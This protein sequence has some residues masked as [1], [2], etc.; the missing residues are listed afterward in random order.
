MLRLFPL[1]NSYMR[2]CLIGYE[3]AVVVGGGFGRPWQLT[4]TGSFA[5]TRII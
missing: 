5:D 2:R 3:Y 1:H 4:G